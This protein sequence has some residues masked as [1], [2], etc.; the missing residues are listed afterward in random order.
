MATLNQLAILPHL[1][2]FYQNLGQYDEGIKIAKCAIHYL[3]ELAAK[4]LLI[5]KCRG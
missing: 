5:T 4:T 2:S 1:A 3:K